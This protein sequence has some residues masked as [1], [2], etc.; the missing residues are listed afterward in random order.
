MSDELLAYGWRKMKDFALVTPAN[1]EV[2]LLT[3]TRP[4]DATVDF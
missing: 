3:M 1:D 4:V 2:G